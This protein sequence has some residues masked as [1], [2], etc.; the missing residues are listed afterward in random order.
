MSEETVSEG[1]VKAFQ[2]NL[3]M[4]ATADADIDSTEDP[5]LSTDSEIEEYATLPA[6][7]NE[8]SH[9]GSRHASENVSRDNDSIAENVT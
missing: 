2:R 6:G 1:Y 8:N 4:M 9:I 3:T 7:Q 5:S